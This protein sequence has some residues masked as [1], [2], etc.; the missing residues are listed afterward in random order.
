MLEEDENENN[1]GDRG[2]DLMEEAINI[3]WDNLLQPQQAAVRSTSNESAFT[4]SMEQDDPQEDPAEIQPHP[5][6]NPQEDPAQIQRQP[7]QNPQQNPQP[8]QQPHPAP[9]PFGQDMVPEPGTSDEEESDDNAN[10]SFWN[11]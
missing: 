7:A 4:F 3:N 2:M 10:D 11:I 9:I 5:A 1:E 6:Q 8:E